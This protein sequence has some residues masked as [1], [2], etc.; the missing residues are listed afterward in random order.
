[1]FN[2]LSM[3]NVNDNSFIQ[4]KLQKHIVVSFISDHSVIYLVMFDHADTDKLKKKPPKN[5]KLNII[6]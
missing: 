4:L 6:K 1:M 2:W 5:F 3:V